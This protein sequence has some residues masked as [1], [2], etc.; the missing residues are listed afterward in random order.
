MSYF[1]PEMLKDIDNWLTWRLETRNGKPTKTPYNPIQRRKQPISI[2]ACSYENA[3]NYW[4][5]GD[6]DG[7]GFYLTPQCNLVFIDLD[8]CIDEEGNY[9]QLAEDLTEKFKDCYIEVSQS[10]R[11]LHIICKGNIQRAIKRADIEIYSQGRYIA[12]TGNALNANE[13]IYKPL[14]L[15]EVYSIYE[16]IKHAENVTQSPTGGYIVIE[17]VQDL[18]YVIRNSRQGAKWERLHNGDLRGYQSVSEG[19]QAYINIVNYFASGNDELTKALF[20]MSAFAKRD[21]YQQAYYIDR[22][23]SNAKAT[24]TYH[25]KPEARKTRVRTG[26]V[27]G[28][29][30]PKRGRKR[31]K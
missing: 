30:N 14:E 11:G 8:N 20:S 4:Q 27:I 18:E 13:P 19:A 24:A 7:I 3:F 2:N 12:L 23:I 22:M 15:E 9:S 29:G 26:G 21:K 31:I 1:I 25:S 10:E 28:S 5:Y 17:T 6:Y 16:P